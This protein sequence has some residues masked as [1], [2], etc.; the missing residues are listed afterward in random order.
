MG[1]DFNYSDAHKCNTYHLHF[2]GTDDYLVHKTGSGTGTTQY[3]PND[4]RAI[5][6]LD[7]SRCSK[8]SRRNIFVG[9]TGDT[10]TYFDFYLSSGQTWNRNKE[11]MMVVV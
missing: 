8:F 9:Y 2:D 10:T 1:R 5:F 7:Q 4:D 3:R 6:P 11:K